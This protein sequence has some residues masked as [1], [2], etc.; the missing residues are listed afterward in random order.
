MLCRLHFYATVG[1]TRGLPPRERNLDFALGHFDFFEAFKL[2]FIGFYW[3]FYVGS[4]KLQIH[5]I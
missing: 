2:L 5:T 1:P 4:P 3:L